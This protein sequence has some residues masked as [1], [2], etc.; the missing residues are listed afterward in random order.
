MGDSWPSMRASELIRV[1][2]RHC[3]P[4]IR[5]R[6]SHRRYKG[7]DAEFTFAYHDG[8]EVTG[9]MVRRVLVKDV[10]LTAHD[11]RGEVS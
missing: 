8:V 7:K 3:G 4:P 6:G 2:E 11:A 1:I 10:G 9:N 5:Q